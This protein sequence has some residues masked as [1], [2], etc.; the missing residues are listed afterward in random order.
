MAVVHLV[1]RGCLSLQG[2]HSLKCPNERKKYF[3]EQL[4]KCVVVDILRTARSLRFFTRFSVA[5]TQLK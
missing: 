4:I 3:I 5:G 1:V 2:V